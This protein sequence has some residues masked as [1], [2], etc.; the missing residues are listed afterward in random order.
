VRGMSRT[1][2]HD[3]RVPFSF[4]DSP[5]QPAAQH[6]LP[7]RRPRCFLPPALLAVTPP[8]RGRVL[9]DVLP[10]AFA[11]SARGTA[12]APGR[13]RVVL[14]NP[15]LPPGADADRLERGP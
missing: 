5:K 3:G 15:C 10:A 8:H 1:R 7:R 6:R 4:S 14:S 11:I 9:P 12:Q 2:G 13:L